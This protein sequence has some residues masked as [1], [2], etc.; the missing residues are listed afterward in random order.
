MGIKSGG[1]SLF[2]N[3]PEE[4]IADIELP[5]LDIKTTLDGTFDYIH[6]FVTKQ[7]EMHEQFAKL[8]NQLK[9]TGMLWVSWP[10]A[11]QQGTD[12]KLTKVIE[13]GYEYGLVESKNLSINATW[14][15]LKFT[16]PKDGKIYNN[17]YGKLKH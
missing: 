14:S 3:A 8:K 10:K 15:A 11:G 12:L 13:I 4:A 2:I 6:L 9:K 16:H 7:Q 17:S 1:R 5:D